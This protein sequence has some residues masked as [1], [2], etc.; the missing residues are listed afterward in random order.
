MQAW[1]ETR[2][3]WP[4][5]AWDPTHESRAYGVG[6]T[7]VGSACSSPVITWGR[8]GTAAGCQRLRSPVPGAQTR[9]RDHGHLHLGRR[10]TA[11]GSCSAEATVKTSPATTSGLS[12]P[13]RSSAP[14]P[15]RASVSVP[16]LFPPSP[17]NWERHEGDSFEVRQTWV[18]KLLSLSEPQ[19]P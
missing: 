2:T 9:G 10:R 15:G 16:P 1:L 8:L 19:F 6:Y 3:S 12:G 4:R 7:R 18:Q 11:I 17:H 13:A 14:T 5:A